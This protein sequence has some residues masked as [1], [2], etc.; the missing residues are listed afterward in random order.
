MTPIINNE[1]LTE[2]P[3]G[4]ENR[5]VFDCGDAYVNGYIQSDRIVRDVQNYETA[6]FVFV[7]PASQTIASYYTLSNTSVKKALF[8]NK[9]RRSLS[10]PAT[11]AAIIG[12]LGVDKN[13]KGNHLGIFTLKRAL[14]R[15][16]DLSRECGCA[17]VVLDVETGNKIALAMYEKAGFKE[18][19]EPEGEGSVALAQTKKLYMTMP[20]IK[21]ALEG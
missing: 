14:Q 17:V 6:A 12:Y 2:K 16:L 19:H 8:S 9:E 10:Y 4:N 21:A 18:F 5:A 20:N 13:F 1:D 11:P 3:L 15:C 7:A